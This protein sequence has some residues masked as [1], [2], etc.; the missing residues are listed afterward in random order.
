M[1]VRSALLTSIIHTR[2]LAGGCHRIIFGLCVLSFPSIKVRVSKEQRGTE[3][4]SHQ[5][6]EG[7]VKVQAC[8]IRATE[9]TR[10]NS[11]EGNPNQDTSQR[12]VFSFINDISRFNLW[13]PSV[14]AA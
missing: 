7:M 9:L 12:K 10:V 3:V 5:Q 1:W 13:L 6:S 11:L 2:D 14:A 8:A 4:Q